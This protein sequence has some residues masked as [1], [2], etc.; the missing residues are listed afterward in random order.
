MIITHS[1]E[2]CLTQLFATN[3][4]SQGHKFYLNW[5]SAVLSSKFYL[6]FLNFEHWLSDK[7]V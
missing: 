3:S 2:A 4:Q 7:K 5:V 6:S 1:I